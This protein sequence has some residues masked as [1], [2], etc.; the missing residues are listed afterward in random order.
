[1]ASLEA[2]VAIAVTAAVCTTIAVCVGGAAFRI[3]GAAI[4]A[5]AAAVCCF[6]AENLSGIDATTGEAIERFQL[7]YAGTTGRGDFTKGI[8][9]FYGISRCAARLGIGTISSPARTCVGTGRACVASTA[10]ITRCACRRGRNPCAYH[11]ECEDCKGQYHHSF[12]FAHIFSSFLNCI[13]LLKRSSI[14]QRECT[15]YLMKTMEV[16]G[17][18]GKSFCLSIKWHNGTAEQSAK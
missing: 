9:A 18:N 8:A 12:D 13:S 17:D 3:G 10:A 2:K 16:L 4:C 6:C 14:I 1:M 11:Q 7:G 15:L 5:G